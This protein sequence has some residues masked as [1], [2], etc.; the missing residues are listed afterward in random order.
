MTYNISAAILAGGES[1]RFKGVPKTEIIVGGRKIISRML[2]VIRDIFD[3]IIIVANSPERFTD[4]GVCKVVK[5]VYP[6]KG[7]LGGIHSAMKASGKEA[8]FVFAGDM[9]FLDNSLIISQIN[10]YSAGSASAIVPVMNSLEEPLH[11]IYRNSLL[12]ET[13]KLLEEPG[14]P[15]VK[16]FLK[17]INPLYID[18]KTSPENKRAFMNINYPSDIDEAERNIKQILF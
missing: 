12:S 6:N 14:I 3:E 1:T 7:P 18:L 15:S 8:L 13:E 11:S 4:T 9:P 16:D 10:I 2:D 17:R 5:D